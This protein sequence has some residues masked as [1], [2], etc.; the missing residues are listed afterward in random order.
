MGS[1][2]AELGCVPDRVLCSTATRC[3]ETWD[4]LRRA[5]R[6]EAPVDFDDA[7]Y[8]ASPEGLLHALAGVIEGDTLLL[9]AHNPG[10]SLLAFELA[11]GR[12]GPDDGMR[13][14]F[15]PATLAIFEIETG[16]AEVSSTGARLR[17]VERP[18]SS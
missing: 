10:V 11:R 5:M 1:R 18:A 6:T 14:G 12:E 13:R 2:L 9:L 4:G 15:S 3:R 8:N 17:A 16:W 7:L